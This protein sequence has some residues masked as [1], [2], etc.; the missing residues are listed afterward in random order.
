MIFGDVL[1]VQAVD[2]LVRLLAYLEV[3][4]VHDLHVV[5]VPE[6]VKKIEMYV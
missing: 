4:V 3:L 5:D 6:E 2:E 1:D